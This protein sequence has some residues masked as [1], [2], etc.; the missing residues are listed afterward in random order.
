MAF[1]VSLDDRPGRASLALSEAGEEP[2]GFISRR[3]RQPE[4]TLFHNRLWMLLCGF[5]LFRC[6]RRG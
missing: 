1:T 5:G 2:I 3:N 6:W 4:T